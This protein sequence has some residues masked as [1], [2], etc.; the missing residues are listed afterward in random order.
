MSKEA[1]K[2]EKKEVTKKTVTKKAATPKEKP[3]KEA[4]VSKEVKEIKEVKEEKVVKETKTSNVK[5]NAEKQGKLKFYSKF[6]YVLA[7]IGKVCTIIAGICL[8]IAIFLTP[9]AVKNVTIENNELRVLNQKVYY[10]EETDKIVLKYG[11]IEIGTMTKEEAQQF[12]N[13]I[14][15]YSNKGISKLF[16]IAEFYLVLSFAMCI[17]TFILLNHLIKLFTLINEIDTPFTKMNIILI[18][19]IIHLVIVLIVAPYICGLIGQILLG[20]DMIDVDLNLIHLLYVLILFT[21]S[22]IFEYGYELQKDTNAK[23]YS[24]T[25]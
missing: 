18:N 10:S 25:K 14:E 19:K 20:T 6:V 7:K 2:K 12:D 11:G 15:E 23:I 3:V 4:K 24:E 1:V 17:V 5:F 13:T 8:M 16:A 22:Y 21:I 9:I